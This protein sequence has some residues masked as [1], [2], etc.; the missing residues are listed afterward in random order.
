MTA[1]IVTVILVNW[2]GREITLECLASLRDVT[3]APLRVVVVDNAS[4]DGSVKAIQEAYPDILVLPQERNLRYA[5]G[6]NVG[7][8]RA[9]ADGTAMVMLLNND[10]TVDPKC[11]SALVAR[12][13]ADERCGMVA[14][15]IYYDHPPDLLWFAGGVISMWTGT[16]RHTGIRE[17]DA[18]RYATPREIDY[19]SGCCILTTREAI[20]KVGMLDESFYMYSEDADWSMRIRQA[21]Y[22]IV[23]EPQAKVWHKLSVSAGGH[24]SGFKLW[25]KFRSNFRFFAR[26]AAWY[27]WLV[28]PWLS[29]LV[30]G[31]SALRYLF[32]S[33]YARGNR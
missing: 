1:P 10:T 4:T 8:R 14:P 6:N 13:Q 22:R 12:I 5:G 17:R 32:T 23:Y 15:R 16:M 29:I 2:N 19:A 18:E 21:G 28:F 7:M 31:V 33:G 20:E 11:V 27:H 24:L 30:H 25:N 3:Y 9:L 26:H